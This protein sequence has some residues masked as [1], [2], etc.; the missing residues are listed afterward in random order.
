LVGGRHLPGL[1]AA[2]APGGRLVLLG[3]LAG[4]AVELDLARLLRQRLTLV[5]STLRGRSRAEKAALVAAFGEFAADRL[6]DGRLQAVIDRVVP[7]GEI[8]EA[9]AAAARG[10]A[11]G[12]IVVALDG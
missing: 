3:L 12:K 2:L 7:W 1:L 8:P 9:Y 10:E 4:A 11:F 6:A 5:G